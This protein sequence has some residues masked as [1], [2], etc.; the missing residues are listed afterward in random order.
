MTKG[1]KSVVKYGTSVNRHIHDRGRTGTRQTERWGEETK[2]KKN[3]YG[4]KDEGQ[5]RKETE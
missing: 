4:V 1:E 3:Y 5:K 2:R